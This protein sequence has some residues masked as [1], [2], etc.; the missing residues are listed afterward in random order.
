MTSIK[1]IRITADI[2]VGSDIPL[3]IAGP[4]VIEGEDMILRHAEIISRIAAEVGMP[5]VFKASYDK[6][7]RTSHSSY[8]GPGLEEGLRILARVRKELEIPVLTD[9]H[10]VQEVKSAAEVVDIIQIPAF[11]CRQTDLLEAAAKTGKVVNVKKGQFISPDDVG[12]IIGKIVNAGGK[13]LMITERGSCFGYNRLIVDFAGLVKMRAH[14]YP[15]IFDATHSVQSPGGLGDR[16]G[17]EGWLAPY[18]A[19]AAAAVGIDGLFIEIHENP[20]EA[21]SDGPNMIPLDSL[22]PVLTRF[23]KI[24]E[25]GR[26]IADN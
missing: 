6:A 13:R 21:L 8:R 7:N 1:T 9:T 20:S 10:S 4:C 23:L 17:G 22:K 15:V 19:W 25:I 5:F 11:L 18:L 2:S 14:G 12:N 26:R 3:L 16:S 24:T